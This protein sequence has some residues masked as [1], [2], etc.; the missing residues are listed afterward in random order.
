MKGSCERGWVVLDEG[1][2]A[3]YVSKKGDNDKRK[4]SF[5]EANVIRG[6]LHCFSS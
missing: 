5:G 3:I 4:G 1:W 2:I 6:I